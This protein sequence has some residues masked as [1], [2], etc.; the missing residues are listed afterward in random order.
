MKKFRTGIIGAGFIGVAHVEALRRLGSVDVVALVDRYNVEDKAKKLHIDQAYNDYKIMIDEVKPDFI[1]ICTPN[2]THFEIAKYA[3]E[4]N[5]NVVLEKP[6]TFS[7][8]EAKILNQ[9]AIDKNLINAVNFHN[10]LYPSNIQMKSMIK[11]NSI[12]DIISITGGYLQDW[13]LYD[14]DYSWRLNAKESG[15]TRAVADIGSHWMDLVEYLTGLEITEVFAE[16]KTHYKNRK[17]PLSNVESF[18]NK[19]DDQYQEIP[20][21]TEDLALIMFRF[22]NGAIG[23]ANI[24]QMAA[25]HKN[26]LNLL[27][28]GTKSSLQWSLTDLETI[29]VGQRDQAN[30]VIP[31]DPNIFAASSTEYPA[32]HTEGFPDAIKHVFK[33]VYHQPKEKHYATFKDGLRQMILCDKIYESSKKQQWIKIKE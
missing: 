33:E 14:T 20:I 19:K 11:E 15:L 25:G 8:E 32:G 12:G 29:K 28:S 2:N 3:L 27:I 5:I 4:H 17:K 23:N 31:K 6:M 21:D 1:H 22:S 30:L 24:S 26:N 7:V 16:F 9:I 10:R 18:S 13:L